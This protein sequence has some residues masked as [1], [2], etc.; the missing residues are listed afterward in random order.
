MEL[1]IYLQDA[2][3]ALIGV[4][5]LQPAPVADH[6]RCEFHG[7]NDFIKQQNL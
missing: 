3:L 6:W 5:V 7:D 2:A 1:L 4:L